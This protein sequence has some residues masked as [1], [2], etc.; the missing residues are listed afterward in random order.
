MSYVTRAGGRM[1]SKDEP[2]EAPPEG[3]TVYVSDDVGIVAAMDHLG[4]SCLHWTENTPASKVKNATE[5][6]V[7][8]GADEGSRKAS[9]PVLDWARRFATGKVGHVDPPGLGTRASNLTDWVAVEGNDLV[10]EIGKA[11]RMAIKGRGEDEP[12]A[13][14]QT[15]KDGRVTV[16]D[17][18]ASPERKDYGPGDHRAGVVRRALLRLAKEAVLFRS[19]DGRHYADVTVNGHRRTHEIRSAGFRRWLTLAY[20]QEKGSPPSAEA[21]QARSACWKRR[22]SMR[23]RAVRPSPGGGNRFGLL[24]RPGR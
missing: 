8:S 11:R 18:E 17:P 19:P 4:Y 7:I 9:Q 13:K 3:G 22:P 10:R 5:V 23:A 12:K 15:P 14:G 16:G 2:T 20:F 1:S 21:M 24:P 6:F